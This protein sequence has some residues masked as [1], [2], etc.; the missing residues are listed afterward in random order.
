MLTSVLTKFHED[1]IKKT[2]TPPN[3]ITINV[4]TTSHEDS[5]IN[6]TYKVV[7]QPE[8][9]P[10]HNWDLTRDLPIPNEETLYRNVSRQT[11]PFHRFLG[12]IVKFNGNI[13]PFHQI[14]F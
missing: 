10:Y 2:A 4:L 12:V 14:I 8:K 3:I 13:Q 1:R 9:L 5:T 11:Y 6:V 7:T